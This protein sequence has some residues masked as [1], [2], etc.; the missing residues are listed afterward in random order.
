VAEMVGNLAVGR[1]VYHILADHN[2]IPVDVDISVYDD[3]Y[4][5]LAEAEDY[6]EVRLVVVDYNLVV[7]C[8]PHPVGM[9]IMAADY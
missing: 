7:E 5:D 2:E 9:A 1:V 4:M 3:S 6:V 8:V